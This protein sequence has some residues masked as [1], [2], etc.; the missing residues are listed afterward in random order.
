VKT[1]ERHHLKENEFA[2]SVQSVSSWVAENR[3]LTVK[4]AAAALIVVVGVGGYSLWRKHTNDQAGSWLGIAMAIADAPVVPPPT[5]PGASQT[6]NTYPTEKAKFEAALTAF[7]EVVNRYPSTSAAMAA[8]VEIASTLLMLNR[9]AESEQA[10]QAIVADSKDS[11]YG[12]M[13]KLGVAE[14][15]AAQGQ[16]DKAITGFTDLAGQRD[17]ALPVDGVL[18]QLAQTYLK[19]GKPKDARAA[20]QQVVD[21]FPNSPYVAEARQRITQLG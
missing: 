19:A 12:P 21:Q 13:A 1:V 2:K 20:F 9:F 10:Y 11:F 8:R 5:L 16:Y 17:G 6:P 4:V 18:M 15:Q 3:D 14:A 7:H